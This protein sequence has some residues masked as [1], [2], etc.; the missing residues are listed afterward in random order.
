[1]IKVVDMEFSFLGKGGGYDGLLSQGQRALCA[2][3]L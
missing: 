3:A 2:R 1:M